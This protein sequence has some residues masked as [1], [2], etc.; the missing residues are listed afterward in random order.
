MNMRMD[1]LPKF[2]EEYGKDVDPAAL[3]FIEC[4]CDICEKIEQIGHADAQLNRPARSDAVFLTLA[5]EMFFDDP[6]IVD[7]VADLVQ[8]CYI[9]GYRKGQEVQ[10]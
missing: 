3:R 9:D 10:A 5:K 7:V 2:K 1:I 4:F 6:E 8:A